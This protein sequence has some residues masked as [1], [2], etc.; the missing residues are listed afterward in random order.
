MEI[1]LNVCR[2]VGLK[3]LDVFVLL[4]VVEKKD[5]CCVCVCLWC[6]FKKGWSFGI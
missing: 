4:D 6:L 2:E 5:I 1:F 3:D